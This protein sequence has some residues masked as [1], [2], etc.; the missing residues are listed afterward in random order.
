MTQSLGTDDVLVWVLVAQGEGQSSNY[1][2]HKAPR[3]PTSPVHFMRM[4][5]LNVYSVPIRW[6]APSAKMIESLD[7]HIDANLISKQECEKK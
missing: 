3:Q 6:T 4:P 2:L 5:L 1:W 7:R